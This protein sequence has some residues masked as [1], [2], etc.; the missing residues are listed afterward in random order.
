MTVWMTEAE[1]RIA[2]LVEKDGMERAS[3]GESDR[4]RFD[5]MVRRGW[6]RLRTRDTERGPAGSPYVTC[7]G[8]RAYEE[9][10]LQSD[11]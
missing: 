1:R 3:F 7:S 4:R 9:G 6:I 11:D 2:L 5:E 10:E 8:M